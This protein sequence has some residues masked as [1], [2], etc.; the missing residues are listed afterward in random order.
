[1]R[2]EIV[3]DEYFTYRVQHRIEA[4]STGELCI[5]Y[6]RERKSPR[7]KRLISASD[8]RTLFTLMV[9]SIACV[10]FRKRN[11]SKFSQILTKPRWAKNRRKSLTT[12]QK[13]VDSIYGT[14]NGIDAVKR[15]KQIIECEHRRKFMLAS[16]IAARSKT[17]ETNLLGKPALAS[18]LNQKNGALLWVQQLAFGTITGKRA[19][20]E[21]NVEAIQLSADTHGFSNSRLGQYLINRLMINVENRYLKDRIVIQGENTNAAMRS[22]I[23]AL[24]QNQVVLSTNNIHAGSIFVEVP[25]GIAAY[26][27]MPV[28]PVSLALLKNIPLFSAATIETEPFSKCDTILEPLYLPRD[29]KKLNSRDYEKIAD[30]VLKMRDR[31]HSTYRQAPEQ[32]LIVPGRPVS[33]F[34]R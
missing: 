9:Y 18:A 32:Y 26:A 20:F 24:A 6:R 1:M 10:F 22:M 7:K 34:S 30:I 23:D 2:Q 8:V 19:L 15:L 5:F 25:F 21:N 27:D 11:W 28:G 12:L 17:Y 4:P 14:N 13:S 31:I 33:K 3:E 16:E 29:G